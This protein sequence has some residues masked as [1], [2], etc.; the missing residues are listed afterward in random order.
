VPTSLF[1]QPPNDQILREAHARVL[2]NRAAFDTIERIAV[3]HHASGDWAGAIAHAAAAAH[4]ASA[5][6]AGVLASPTLERVLL[7]IGR[8]LVP[9]MAETTPS[10]DGREHVLH[11]FT[12]TYEVGGHTRLGRRWIDLDADRRHSVFLTGPGEDPPEWLAGAAV[13]SGGTVAIA[14]HGAS[15]VER[16]RRLRAAAATADVVVLHV[17]MYDPVPILAFADPAGRPPVVLANHA[18][19]VLWLGV[20]IA[21]VVVCFRAYAAELAVRRRGVDP[22]RCRV[23]GVPLPAELPEPDRAAARRHHGVDPDRPVLLTIASSYKYAPAL[24]PAMQHL[25]AA[26]LRAVPDAVL[27]VVGPEIDTAWQWAKQETQDR[28]C[29]LGRVSETFGLLAIADLYLD[30]W[31]CSSGTS[32]LEAALHGVPV[33]GFEPDRARHGALTLHLD[34]I[35]GLIVEAATEQEYAAQI[36]RLIHDRAG[37]RALGDA[38]RAGIVD[39]HCGPA[40]RAA[41]E[42]VMATARAAGPAPAP[43]APFDGEIE[44]WETLLD[45]MHRAARMTPAPQGALLAQGAGLDAWNAAHAHT[46]GARVPIGRAVAAPRVEAAVVDAVVEGFRELLAAGSVAGCAVAVTADELDAAAEL[47]EEALERGEDIDIEVLVLHGPGALADVLT[48]G[49]LCLVEPGSVAEAV[50]EHAGLTV[51]ALIPS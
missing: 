1:D 16:A 24:A 39:H 14:P 22:T 17:H 49:D 32:L 48:P 12:E 5:A 34:S 30:S 25:A 10:A 29:V 47:L 13:R 41:L 27:L 28:V 36:R 45:T 43:A 40:W 6:P 44:T 19:H 46:G 8:R 7:D 4:L 37:R 15:A 26:A 20:G 31:P 11:V 42:D 33:V 23:L 35:E 3:E 50:A 38:T 21:D 18:D 9:A 51:R 2:D